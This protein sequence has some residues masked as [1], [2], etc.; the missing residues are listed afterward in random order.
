MCTPPSGRAADTDRMKLVCSG[1][2]ISAGKQMMALSMGADAIYTARGFMLAIGC[3][4][5]LRCNNNTCPVGI[6]TH[7]EKLQRGLDIE[8]KAD[9]IKNYVSNLDHY[10]YEIVAAMGRTDFLNLNPDNLIGVEQ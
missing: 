1:K 5:A 4:Q 8:E 2:L 9:R 7:S 3:I 10:H 6:T